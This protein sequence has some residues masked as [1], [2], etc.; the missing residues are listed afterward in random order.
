MEGKTLA[1]VWTSDSQV[2]RAGNP[3][4]GGEVLPMET[5]GW[6]ENKSKLFP[7]G[8]CGDCCQ[9]SAPDKMPPLCSASC[10]FIHVIAVRHSVQ[11]SSTWHSVR[12]NEWQGVPQLPRE[13][14]AHRRVQR[15]L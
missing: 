10:V 2:G 6:A 4:S 13:Q 8:Q 12:A 7:L 1:E 11:F 14:R 15:S 5:D 9:D 3:L